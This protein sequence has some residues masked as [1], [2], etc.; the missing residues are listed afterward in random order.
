LACGPAAQ[1]NTDLAAIYNFL[2]GSSTS[3]ETKTWGAIKDMYGSG[4]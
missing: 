1:F 4:R 2:R 3:V